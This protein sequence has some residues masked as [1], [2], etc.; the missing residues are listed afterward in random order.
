[1]GMGPYDLAE[2]HSLF[3][4]NLQAQSSSSVEERGTVAALLM[5]IARLDDVVS[6]I[7][8]LNNSLNSN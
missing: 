7:R 6:G 2:E 8:A 1:M 3:L 4:R 5:L